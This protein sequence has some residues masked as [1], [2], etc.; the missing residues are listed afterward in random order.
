MRDNKMVFVIITVIFGN[1]CRGDPGVFA[2]PL[3]L[4]PSARSTAE[5]H[6]LRQASPLTPLFSRRHK[7]GDRSDDDDD[8]SGSRN[9]LDTYRRDF[10]AVR[11]EPVS[12]SINY[13][14]GTEFL[15]FKV[16]SSGLL[17]RPD[18]TRIEYGDSI[19]ISVQVDSSLLLVQ[20]L[21]S[22]L[23]FDPKRPA[24]LNISYAEADPDLN[25]DGV[26]DRIDREIVR[27]RLALWVQ[28]EVDDPWFEQ[29]AKHDRGRKR[30]RGRLRHFSNYA[31]SW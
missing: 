16:P 5:M 13:V 26:V 20:L 8:R 2:P 12:V 31:V 1:G 9:L 28:Q 30:F 23:T 7:N 24:S 21:P 18:G 10:W 25:G 11:G 19:L 22:G 17:D 27:S 15:R 3:E 4:V 14:S 29:G 6:F